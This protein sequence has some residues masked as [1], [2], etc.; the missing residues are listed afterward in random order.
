MKKDLIIAAVGLL[1]IGPAYASQKTPDRPGDA[2]TRSLLAA[3]LDQVIRT[4]GDDRAVQNGLRSAAQSAKANTK[5]AE[6][7][8]KEEKLK[9]DV[10]DAQGRLASSW[11][12]FSRA[13]N[14]VAGGTGTGSGPKDP[15]YTEALNKCKSIVKQLESLHSKFAVLGRADRDIQLMARIK[16]EAE[17]M[18]AVLTVQMRGAPD[19]PFPKANTRVVVKRQSLKPAQTGQAELRKAIGGSTAIFRVE[20]GQLIVANSANSGI[21]AMVPIT[22]GTII[23]ANL[24]EA[25]STVGFSE[26]DISLNLSSITRALNDTFGLG[27]A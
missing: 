25:L 8:A 24:V 16:D 27:V 20:G 11:A 7:S 15:A 21:M 14:A 5:D 4:S 13:F 17:K 10:A 23:R 12:S 26:E 18:R 19:K 2:R 6:T 9:H 3:A 22:S 1:L